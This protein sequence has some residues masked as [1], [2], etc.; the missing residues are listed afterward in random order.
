M[1]W[2]I[3]ILHWEPQVDLVCGP[4]RNNPTPNMLNNQRVGL[5]SKGTVVPTLSSASNHA[6]VTHRSRYWPLPRGTRAPAQASGGAHRTP[7]SH[8]S[9][10]NCCRA[11]WAVLT[12]QPYTSTQYSLERKRDLHQ[13]AGR[14]VNSE[15][16]P[17]S[18]MG[19]SFLPWDH[20]SYNR[21][22]NDLTF[23]GFFLPLMQPDSHRALC[24]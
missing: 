18:P 23:A 19:S 21:G 9:L 17:L 3:K 14:Q 13:Q 12:T 24:L 5:K 7:C 6:I 11:C 22:T 2:V 20:I 4:G 1:A 15:L 16:Q 10:S 8:C